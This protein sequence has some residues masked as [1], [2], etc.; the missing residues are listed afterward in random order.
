[1]VNYFH[2]RRMDYYAFDKADKRVYDYPTFQ[3]EN[4][5]NQPADS[6]ITKKAESSLKTTGSY[7]TTNGAKLITESNSTTFLRLQNPS[8]VP[9][10]GRN[11]EI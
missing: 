2:L 5:K 9:P 3:P 11:T 1:M 10:S 8:Y 4:C 7:S 6:S